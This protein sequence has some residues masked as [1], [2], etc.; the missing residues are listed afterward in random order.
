[1]EHWGLSF[2]GVMIMKAPLIEMGFC[3][4]FRWSGSLPSYGAIFEQC[5]LALQGVKGDPE[6]LKASAA[7]GRPGSPV[8]REA[9]TSE[10]IG[11]CGT[12]SGLPQCMVLTLTLSEG[13]CR[14]KH[15]CR[16]FVCL[17][18]NLYGVDMAPALQR[19]RRAGY[20]KMWSSTS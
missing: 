7:L 1:M 9:L 16:K 20:Y 3:A 17:P 6:S 2:L 12:P 4:S 8:L 14:M 13:A 15:C 18:S 10:S 5:R 19:I 11:L